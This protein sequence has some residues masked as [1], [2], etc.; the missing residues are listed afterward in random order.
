MSASLE[1]RWQPLC[2]WSLW[3]PNFL[4]HVYIFWSIPCLCRWGTISSDGV[5]KIPR[6]INCELFCAVGA[7][8]RP[9]CARASVVRLAQE[10]PRAS[11]LALNAFSLLLAL[12]GEHFADPSIFPQ[13]STLR[14]GGRM[15]I[16]DTSPAETGG[17]VAGGQ[18]ECAWKLK[19]PTLQG[20]GNPKFRFWLKLAKIGK[21]FEKFCTFMQDT[22]FPATIWDFPQFRH[23]SVKLSAK[24]NIF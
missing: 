15:W 14:P 2:V 12:F 4:L 13:S 20:T 8:S 23:T 3:N 19:P 1:L 9:V 6:S 21:I 18:I 17:P 5:R 16:S 22:L 24:N 11:I 10:Q 7:A